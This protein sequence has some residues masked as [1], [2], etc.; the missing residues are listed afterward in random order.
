M[1]SYETIQTTGPDAGL[2]VERREYEYDQTLDAAGNV[3]RVKRKVPYQPAPD[4]QGWVVFA[5]EFYYNKAGEMQIITQR[6]W[7]SAPLGRSE[8]DFSVLAASL[9]EAI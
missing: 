3:V 7:L 8:P 2:V 1:L 4:P 5:T 6:M 9:H